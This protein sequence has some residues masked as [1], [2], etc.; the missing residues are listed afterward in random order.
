MNGAYGGL[1][2]LRG[3]EIVAGVFKNLKGE[4][5][6]GHANPL[7]TDLVT[8]WPPATVY[9]YPSGTTAMTISSSDANDDDGGDGLQTARAIG[10][11]D[12]GVE[13]VQMLTMDGQSGVAIPIELQRA[14][15][16]EGV[17]AGASDTNVGTIYVGSGAIVD[18]VPAN[19]FALMEP[20]TGQTQQTPYTVLAGFRG[21]VTAIYASLGGT[22]DLDLQLMA[23]EPGEIFRVRE[24]WHIRSGVLVMPLD[25]PI[26]PLPALTDIELRGHLDATTFEVAAS[27]DI[28]LEEVAA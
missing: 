23:R 17:T 7:G 18:G 5:K 13:Q 21:F 2:V 28:V 20:G 22:K 6:F 10:L 4:R 19:V 11:D 25:I 3:L 24:H 1:P 27:Y 8:I 15:R 26:G 9:V 14:Y 12:D 16:I